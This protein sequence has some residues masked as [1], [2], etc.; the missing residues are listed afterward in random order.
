MQAAFHGATSLG[1]LLF[2]HPKK[3]SDYPKMKFMEYVWACDPIG[4]LLFICS[5]TLM[6]L[7]LDWAGG[8]YAW[9]D[10]HVAVPLS[11]GLALLVLF[12]VYGKRNTVTR[13]IE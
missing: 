8:A 3:R 11:L 7:G 13:S 6:L 4:C 10:P 5:A 2:Y 9:S 12:C 1:L